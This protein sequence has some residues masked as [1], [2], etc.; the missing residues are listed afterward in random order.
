[1]ARGVRH[2]RSNRVGNGRTAQRSASHGTTSTGGDSQR[3][4]SAAPRQVE[5]PKKRGR[6]LG[7]Q[8]KLKLSHQGGKVALKPEGDM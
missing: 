8:T 4:I 5:T 2:A 1:M 6:K 7:S 3:T